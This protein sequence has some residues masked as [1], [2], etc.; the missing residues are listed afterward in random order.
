MKLTENAMRAVAAAQNW[1]R[2]LGHDH[3][4]AEHVFLGILNNPDCQACKNLK[5][6]GFAPQDLSETLRSTLTSGSSSVLQVG[7]LPISTRLKKIFEMAELEAG[8]DNEVGTVYLVS[9]MLREGDNIAAQLLFN[10]GV[11]LDKFLAA[12]MAKGN[13]QEDDDDVP[14]VPKVAEIL[15][16][17]H[18][19]NGKAQKTPT[20]NAF[21]RDL[22]DLARQ[23]KLDPVIGREKEL[24]R[25][26]QILGRRTKNNAVLIGEAGVGKT[27]VVEGLAQ[28]IL[29][30]DV[31][32]RLQSK[33]VVAVDMA[34]VVAGTQYLSLIHI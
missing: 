20:V 14:A 32:E 24:K 4:G 9:A 23:G 22:T 28:A 13:A 33:R 1:A 31:P 18:G 27:A 15:G 17:T 3:I 5:T 8:K 16:T 29:R 25:V 11:T 19:E 26:V 2:Q 34:R 6:L 21:G 7:E 12:G 30:G 10:A